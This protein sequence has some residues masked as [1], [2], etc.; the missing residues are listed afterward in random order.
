MGMEPETVE[1]SRV[2]VDYLKS[3]NK[4]AV[5]DADALKDNAEWELYPN[6]VITPHA[7]E[8]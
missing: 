4:P 1:A 7:G 8:F 2:I 3:L 5:I 6:A